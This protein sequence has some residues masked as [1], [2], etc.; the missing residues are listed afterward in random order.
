MIKD[1]L[2]SAIVHLLASNGTGCSNNKIFSFKVR[3]TL[4][5]RL[6]DEQSRDN[7]SIWNQ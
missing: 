1:F 7:V 4:L 5:G 6:L 3:T 2:R